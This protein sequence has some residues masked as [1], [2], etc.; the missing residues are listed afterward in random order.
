MEV[1][2]EAL[3]YVWILEEDNKNEI[4]EFLKNFDKKLLNDL[5]KNE[6]IVVKDNK[7]ELTEKGREIAKNIVRRHR[8]AEFLLYN[9]FE[10]EEESYEEFACKF[11]HIVDE[12]ITDKICTFL[13]HPLYCPHGRK[14]PRGKCC[15]EKKKEIESIIKPLIELKPGE[16]AEIVYFVTESKRLTDSLISHGLSPKKKIILKQIYPTVIIQ[17]DE[18]II[19]FDREIAKRIYVKELD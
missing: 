17:I 13:G 8:L 18:S 4:D 3:E 10:I 12:E 2:E 7:L 1:I 5:I 15:I 19:S 11:E 16:K 14:I 9:V 6:Y